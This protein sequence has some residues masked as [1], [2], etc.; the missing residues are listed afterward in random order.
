MVRFGADQ[1][2]SGTGGGTFTD[3]DID[4]LIARG[5]EKTAAIQANLRED[6]KHSLANFSLLADD[7]PDTFS[8]H[9][10]NYRE[11]SKTATGNFINLPQR[12]RKRNYDLNAASRETAGMKAHAADAATKK[13]RKGPAIHD[14]QLFDMAKLEA[15]R[16]KEKRLAAQK[17]AHVKR[18][19]DL[20]KQAVDAP[21]LGSG[22]AAGRS[23][24]E[25]LSQ[26]EGMERKLDEI[27]LSVED[28]EEQKRLLAEGFPDWSKKDFKAFC[29]AL[30]VHGRYDFVSISRDVAAETG[31]DA[32]EIGRYFIAFW[33]Y[34]R[35]INDWEKVIDRIER[36]EKKILRL[37]QIRDAIQEKVERHLEDT[38][39]PHYAESGASQRI[40]SVAELLYYSWPKMKINYGMAGKPK[41]YQEEEDSFLVAMMYRHGY[42]AAERIRMEIRRAWQFRFDWYFKSR[43]G[44]E[45]QKRCDA[46]VKIIERENEDV[47]KREADAQVTRDPQ[48]GLGMDAK[49]M[50]AEMVDAAGTAAN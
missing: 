35:R 27:K 32:R 2:L 18:I 13:R 37:R 10:K 45:I 50:D 25:L 9:G 12:Q 16:E 41:G 21:T 14:F 39:G 34:Y 20:R 31:K 23:R 6:A 19:A 30:E 29:T 44:Q 49:N 22:V 36:G 28:D 40:P 4:A 38:F 26:A 8:F 24:E 1:I 46:I 47:R 11:E 33:Q 17:E 48:A 15:L 3:E 42:G 43:S 7:G 5:E